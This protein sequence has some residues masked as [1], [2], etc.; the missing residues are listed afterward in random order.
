MAPKPA[1]LPRAIVPFPCPDKSTWSETWAQRGSD[2]DLMNV[3]HSFR[4]LLIAPPNVGKTT[5]IKNMI[6]HQRPAFKEVWVVHNDP[7]SCDYDDLGLYTSCDQIPNESELIEATAHDGDV[8]DPEDGSVVSSD[9]KVKS[10]RLII[11]EDMHLR[12]MKPD[13]AY[14]VDRLLKYVSSHCSWSVMITCQDAFSVD[15]SIRRM[16]NFFVI[17]RGPDLESYAAL[18]S[19]VGLTRAQF[20]KMLGLLKEKHDTLW[21]DMTDLTPARFRLNCYSVLPEP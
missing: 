11:I 16:M 1:P 5:T 14:N 3:P 6:M 12:K 20:M 10:K 9:P 8:L 4:C 19:R 15:A 18:A 21:L 17:G 2:P 13:D 7:Q